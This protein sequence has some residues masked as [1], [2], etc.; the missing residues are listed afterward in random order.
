MKKFD[1]AKATMDTMCMCA[2]HFCMTF[3]VF[4]RYIFHIKGESLFCIACMYND[5]VVSNRKTYQRLP[6]YF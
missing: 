4:F 2:W 6:V 3:Y 1:S 5:S